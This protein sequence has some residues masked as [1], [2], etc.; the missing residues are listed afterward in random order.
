MSFNWSDPNPTFIKGSHWQ[1]IVDAIKS[2]EQSLGISHHPISTPSVGGLIRA[3]TITT[4][5]EAVDRIK[6]ENV[7][8][9]HYDADH[10]TNRAAPHFGVHHYEN[11]VGHLHSYNSY[12]H[13]NLHNAT[14][15]HGSH[16]HIDDETDHTGY[17]GANRIPDD[18]AN[19][20]QEDGT[21]LVTYYETNFMPDNSP[22]NA[23][24]GDYCPE[25]S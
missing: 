5:K 25:H 13:Y 12:A 14:G 11:R 16:Q 23:T 1:E 22:D 7:C 2:L 15:D 6:S 18:T 24:Y 17:L 4:Y 8:S 20:Y 3:S 10:Q 19:Y 21:H 9:S